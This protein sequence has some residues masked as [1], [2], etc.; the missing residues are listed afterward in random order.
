MSI[1]EAADVIC[2][3]RPDID[4]HEQRLDRLTASLNEWRGMPLMLKAHKALEFRGQIMQR[5][6]VD[7]PITHEEILEMLE[8]I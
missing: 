5:L 1:I 7:K 4:P 8:A 3:A 6:A 2:R